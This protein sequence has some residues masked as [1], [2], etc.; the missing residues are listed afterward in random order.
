LDSTFTITQPITF[1]YA[2]NS[3]DETCFNACD[4]EIGIQPDGTGP[5]GYAWTPNVGNTGNET[6]LCPGDYEILVA[7][8]DGCTQVLNVTITGPAEIV[9]MVSSDVSEVCIGGSAVLSAVINGGV[10]P[11]NYLWTAVPADPTLVPNA[12]NPTVFPAVSTSYT[13][14]VTDANGCQSVPKVVTIDVLPPLDLDVIRPLFS[15]DTSICPYDFG[16]INL[17]AAGGDGNYSIYLLPDAVNPIS[18]PIDT[19]PLVTTPSLFWNYRPL[20]LMPIP[21]VA[22]TRLRS[23]SRILLSLP[24]SVGTGILETLIHQAIPLQ[25][26]IPFTFILDQDCMMFHLV[27]LPRQAV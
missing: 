26:K 13:L 10:A 9:S 6:G 25:F 5:Y 18:L 19:Q 11:F 17:A 7:D 4:G 2:L 23:I 21:I 14:V 3:M 8:A 12:V 15:P 20:S 22:A 16:T 1:N 24:R 27:L